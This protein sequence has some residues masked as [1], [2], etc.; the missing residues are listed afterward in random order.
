MRAHIRRHFKKDG[1]GLR[2]LNPK[3]LWRYS[4]SRGNSAKAGF[5]GRDHFAHLQDAFE[6]LLVQYA[7]SAFGRGSC[8]G[9]VQVLHEDQLVVS[10]VV[11]QLVDDLRGKHYPEPAGAHPFLLPNL[12]VAERVVG[13]ICEC[14]VL[15]LAEI[16]AFSGI[17]DR[18]DDG[19][20]QTDVFDFDPLL[21]IAFAAVLDG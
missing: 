21:V 19:S 6:S 9:R 15:H 11:D 20:L 2:H 1:F 4:A 10:I 3:A 5:D 13:W 7:H 14:R 17:L 12:H 16:E 18:V 8:W